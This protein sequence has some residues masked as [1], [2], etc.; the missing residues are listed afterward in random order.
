[1]GRK[2]N[3]G[4]NFPNF[5]SLYKWE[6]ERIRGVLRLGSGSIEKQWAHL[7][8]W[9]FPFF[10]INPQKIGRCGYALGFC[11]FVTILIDYN[12]N[13]FKLQIHLWICLHGP[14]IRWLI[15]IRNC[16]IKMS[17]NTRLSRVR[18]VFLFTFLLFLF[19]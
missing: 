2:I 1:M 14:F 16:C 15:W 7:L 9:L 18:N 13:R 8:N 6:W 12:N 10:F 3:F 19:R 11:F 5:N 17:Q 4:L